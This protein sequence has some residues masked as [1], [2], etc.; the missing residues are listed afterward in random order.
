M[1]LMLARSHLW[2]ERAKIHLTVQSSCLVCGTKENLNVHHK[3]PYSY[4]IGLG[5][6]DLELDER[7]L[8]TLCEPHHLIVGHLDWFES[9]NPKLEYFISL[10][11]GLLISQIRSL[12]D[13]RN[14][15]AFRPLPYN[16]MDATARTYLMHEINDVM[17]SPQQ[18]IH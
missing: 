8:F 16:R 14:A 15:V 13:W 18:G 9:Y 7:N 3:Y 5:R 4:I 2:T 10:C 6:P 11:R 12:Q 1:D 17:G